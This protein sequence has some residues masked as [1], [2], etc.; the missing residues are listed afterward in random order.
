MADS[1]G[2]SAPYQ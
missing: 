2:K 1:S